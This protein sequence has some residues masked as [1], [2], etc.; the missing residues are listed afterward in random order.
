VIE[1]IKS[2]I[3]INK[4]TPEKPGSFNYP[5]INVFSGPL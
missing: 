3:S 2:L 1:L 5:A 4:K